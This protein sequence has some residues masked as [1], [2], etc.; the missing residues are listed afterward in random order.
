M[1]KFKLYF[2]AFCALSVLFSCDKASDDITYE[3]LRYYAPQY[4][5]ESKIIEDYLKTHYIEEII[6]NPGATNDQDIKMSLIPDNNTTLQPI[7]DSPLLHSKDVTFNGLTYKV[8]YLQLREGTGESPSRVDNVLTAYDG[9]YLAMESVKVVVRNPDGTPVLDGNGR[10]TTKSM[11]LPVANR[12]QY[13]PFPSGYFTLSATITGWRDI[14]PLFKEGTLI[15]GEGPNPATYADFGA[16]VMFLPSALAYYN[17]SQTQT[18]GNVTVTTIPAYS[19]LIFSFKLYDMQRADQDGDGVLSVDEDL[20]GDG[21]FTNDD[22]DGDGKQNFSD[23][24]DD[25]DGYLTKTEGTGD[26]DGDGIPNYLDKDSH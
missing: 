18:F 14:F 7:W 3:Q 23:V 24:D 10:E 21:L 12:F 8:Y 15:P 25:G 19:P 11:T 9:S 5:T 26:S 1:N 6:N 16:G 2:I 4:A 20:N 22:T 13:I 17:V